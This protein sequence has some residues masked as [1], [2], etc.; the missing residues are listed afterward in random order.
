MLD[1]GP[2][3]FFRGVVLVECFSTQLSLGTPLNRVSLQLLGFIN[4][5]LHIEHPR[6]QKQFENLAGRRPTY[7]GHWASC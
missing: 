7:W 4:V 3:T 5:G 2:H 6:E 1:G